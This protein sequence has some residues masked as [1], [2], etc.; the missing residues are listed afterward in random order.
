MPATKKQT[1]RL[2]LL[3]ELLS[4]KKWT[5][6]ELFQRVNEKMDGIEIT[7]RSFFRDIQDLIEAGA[8]LHRPEKGDNLYYYTHKYSLKTMLL[9]D[10]DVAI[11]KKAISVLRQVEDF[12][13]MDELEEVIQKLENRAHTNVGEQNTTVQFEK[14]TT[15]SGLEY[16]DNLLDAIE[17]KVPVKISYHPFIFKEPMEKVVHP[18]LL[19]EFRNRWFLIAREG[20]SAYVNNYALDRIKK[21]KNSD[22]IFIEND[23]FNPDT[24]F[25][26]LIG[27]SVPRGSMPERVQIKVYKQS[28]PYINSKPIHHSQMILKQNKDG[29]MLIQLNLI[30]NFELKSIL[31]SYGAGIEIKKPLSLRQEM[32][33]LISDMKSHYK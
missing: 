13:M 30:I 7:K 1:K 15:S 33:D 4:R 6:D 10:D 21:I 11:L 9:D 8:P 12:Q 27:V 29:S 24:Y 19:K 18:Y 2:E 31:L 25:N 32:S 20:H 17:A 5:V 26:S 23:L 28:T 16:F 14:H 3:D 22:A